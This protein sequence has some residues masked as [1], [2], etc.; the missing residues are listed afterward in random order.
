[1]HFGRLLLGH[2]PPDDKRDMFVTLTQDMR[3]HTSDTW[4]A[5]KPQ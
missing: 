2:F 1:M 4:D 3:V 5:W